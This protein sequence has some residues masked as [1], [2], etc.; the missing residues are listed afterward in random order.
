VEDYYPQGY[1]RSDYEL[2]FKAVKVFIAKNLEAN[3]LFRIEDYNLRNLVSA[4][5]ISLERAEEILRASIEGVP[6]RYFP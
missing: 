4:N 2:G 1:L 5:V 6:F 3:R